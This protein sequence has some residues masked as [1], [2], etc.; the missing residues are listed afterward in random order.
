MNHPWKDLNEARA[1]VA[2][3]QRR[4]W[5]GFHIRTAIFGETI[6]NARVVFDGGLWGPHAIALFASSPDRI[7]GHFE[8]YANV[9]QVLA[10]M[11]GETVDFSGAAG[12]LLRW[13]NVLK[14]TRQRVQIQWKYRHGGMSAPRWVQIK[15]ICFQ[16][17]PAKPVAVEGRA[18]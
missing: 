5:G 17:F 16:R 8:G 18:S 11:V 6:E 7:R 3:M 15:E 12:G 9:N 2:P 1:I 14:A 10:P 4:A 13:A